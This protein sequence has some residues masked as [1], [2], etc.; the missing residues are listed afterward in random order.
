MLLVSAAGSGACV[1]CAEAD[2]SFLGVVTGLGPGAGLKKYCEASRT[3]IISA[4]A[5]GSRFSKEGGA[6]GRVPGLLDMKGF[7]LQLY[8]TGL[9]NGVVTTIAERM[10]A[11]QAL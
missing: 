7:Q 6:G 2:L 4:R 10:A 1:T 9:R 11:R 8:G 5:N 3:S